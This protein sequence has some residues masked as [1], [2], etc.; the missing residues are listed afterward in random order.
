MTLNADGTLQVVGSESSPD[1]GQTLAN[2]TSAAVSGAKIAGGVPAAAL[3][4]P[5]CNDGAV[6]LDVIPYKEYKAATKG[7]PAGGRPN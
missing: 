5:P 7:A 6:V 3:G 4:L 2:L 1:R